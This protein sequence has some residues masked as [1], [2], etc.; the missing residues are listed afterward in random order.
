MTDDL[1]AIRNLSYAYTGH[2]DDGDWAA[3]ADLLADAEL[4]LVSPG[5]VDRPIQG[6]AA[7][8]RFYADQ[9]ITY[10]GSPRTR[11]IVSNH[12]IDLE[13]DSAEGRSYFHVLQALPGL[14]PEI[15]VVG[16]Y[17]D[18]FV[19]RDAGWQF[20]AKVI[21]AEWFGHIRNHFRIGGEHRDG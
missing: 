18:S 4:R 3:V 9:V 20:A 13:G 8:E 17:F 7:V 5:M 6:R 2:L 12:V 21:Q 10:R 16:Q 15:V 1:Q 14:A 19:R 11:H